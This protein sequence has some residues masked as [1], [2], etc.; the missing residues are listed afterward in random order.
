MNKTIS[1]GELK[2]KQVDPCISTDSV[3]KVLD[4]LRSAYSSN[5]DVLRA[6]DVITTDLNTIDIF[7]DR[8]E[9]KQEFKIILDHHVEFRMKN[10]ILDYLYDQ[11]CKSY[12]VEESQIDDLLFEYQLLNGTSKIV[13]GINTVNN[14]DVDTKVY[15]MLGL[16]GL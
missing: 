2:L 1:V 16:G 15:Y 8:Y 4:V 6:I 3:I 14:I 11:K 9:N 7:K 13:D 5:Q 12:G 10:Y